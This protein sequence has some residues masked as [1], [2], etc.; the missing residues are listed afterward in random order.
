MAEIKKH[1]DE[2]L[3]K[4]LKECLALHKDY[5]E[6]AKSD[7]GEDAAMHMTNHFIMPLGKYVAMSLCN[8]AE[9]CENENQKDT[10]LEMMRHF[11]KLCEGL[12]INYYKNFKESD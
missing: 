1:N 11:F 12:I 10:A 3:L 2:L 9:N 5:F 7:E 6:N 4:F 8:L